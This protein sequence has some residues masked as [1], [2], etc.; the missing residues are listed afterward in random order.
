[1][2]PMEERRD[3][4]MRRLAA[5]RAGQLDAVE[6]VIAAFEVPVTT[7]VNP[8]SDFATPEFGEAM[9]DVLVAHHATS[10]EPFTKD[11]SEYALVRIF[12]ALGHRAEKSPRTF[13][14]QDIT[15]DD[16]RF[17]VKTQA[18]SSISADELHISKFM[19]LGRGAWEDEE[20]LA[21]LRDRMLEHLTHYERI[22]DVRCLSQNRRFA[23]TG[24]IHYELVEIPKA[25][26]ERAAE[27][28]ITM[29][30]GSR[31]NPKPG[32]GRVYEGSGAMRGAQLF[33][34]Y[35][36]GGTERKLQ[37]RH[38]RKS[39]CIVHATWRFNLSVA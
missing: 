19:E 32:Y 1:M 23:G 39:A 28:D 13:P 7:W 31:Q 35:F 36:D 24:T 27:A 6:A 18:D 5:L 9:A 26:L 21:A 2:L 30:H 15:V 16:V 34:L 17:S 11:K 12:G 4:L 20:D 25:L 33:E 29:E 38:L 37:V 22:L 3:A 14:G 10:L 8:E